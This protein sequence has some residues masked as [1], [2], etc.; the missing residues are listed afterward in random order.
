M[1]VNASVTV[2]TSNKCVQYNDIFKVCTFSGRIQN[3]NFFDLN[4]ILKRPLPRRYDSR[5]NIRPANILYN[6]QD[7]TIASGGIK[8]EKVNVVLLK[9]CDT[10]FNGLRNSVNKS[11]PV[12]NVVEAY[13]S[14]AP[15][16]HAKRRVEQ[17]SDAVYGTIIHPRGV[18]VTMPPIHLNRLSE[19][20]MCLGNRHAFREGEAI[21]R[22]MPGKD[23]FMIVRHEDELC[24]AAQV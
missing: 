16:G 21:S 24:T 15:L 14:L 9:I 8:P 22:V 2:S 1:L 23:D 18:V 6:E 12:T 17:A 10:E 13:N 19:D 20:T 7:T 5:P 3:D 11:A 4:S